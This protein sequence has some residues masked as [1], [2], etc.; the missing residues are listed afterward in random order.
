MDKYY[1]E[2]C[3]KYFSC[4]SFDVDRD[5]GD[6]HF[7]ENIAGYEL[8]GKA[9]INEEEDGKYN[10]EMEIPCPKCES[11]ILVQVNGIITFI[12]D[13][14]YNVDEI[15]ESSYNVVPRSPKFIPYFKTTTENLEK[16][17]LKS[18]PDDDDEKE[19]TPNNNEIDKIYCNEFVYFVYIPQL[20][21]IGKN[22]VKIGKTKNLNK[23]IMSLQTGCPFK[24]RYYKIIKTKDNS[25]LEKYFHNLFKSKCIRSE[26]FEIELTEID[27]IILKVCHL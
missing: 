3:K 7:I 25:K 21:N 13:E 12:I 8:A 2:Y 19:N 18:F 14:M 10:F 26:W 15:I 23:R 16:E 9:N 5:F 20:V 11:N 6:Y 27:Y 17:I 4:N 24:L 22:Y 1:C